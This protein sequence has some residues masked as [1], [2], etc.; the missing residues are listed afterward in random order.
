VAFVALL[1]GA[2]FLP[3]LLAPALPSRHSGSRCGSNLRQLGLA[4]IQYSD[5]KRFFPHVKGLRELDDGY[6][7]NHAAKSVRALQYYGY[8]DNPEGWICPSSSDTFV[9]ITASAVQMDP[10][11]WFWNGTSLPTT[12]TW[13]SPF[14]DGQPDPTLRETPELSYG[15]TRK[16]MNSNARS[17]SLLSADRA[18][19][20]VEGTGA[21]ALAGE[22]GNHIEGTYVLR[23]DA[24]VQLHATGAPPPRGFAD[25]SVLTERIGGR[26]EKEDPRARWLRAIGVTALVFALLAWFGYMGFAR[27]GGE[28]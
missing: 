15:W 14:V 18:V 1:L 22:V 7:S 8:H 28:S 5:D 25:L 26:R 9:H 20:E 16:G 10:R 2:G 21:S 13:R 6:D 19:R 17:I 4:A 3:V 27:G 23:V 11:L 12:P 24:T